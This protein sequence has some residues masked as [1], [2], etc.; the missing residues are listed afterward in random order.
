MSSNIVLIGK[1]YNLKL[2]ESHP[3]EYGKVII[4]DQKLAEADKDKFKG[5]K[6]EPGVVFVKHPYADVYVANND[7]LDVNLA[8]VMMSE[9]SSFA[10]HLGAL[11]VHSSIEIT[12]KSWLGREIKMSASDGKTEGKVSSKREQAYE[13]LAKLTAIS[14]L[15]NQPGK[16]SKEEYKEAIRIYDNSSFLRYCDISGTCKHMLDFRDPDKR[17]TEKVDTLE[18]VAP[19]NLT[20]DLKIAGS[21]KKAPILKANASFSQKKKYSKVFSIRFYANFVESEK[22]ESPLKK[23][24]NFNDL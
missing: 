6:P 2:S 5:A 18:F 11:T 19:I 12:E 3:R 1:N 15:D 24:D 20:D 4:I 17:L 22:I 10:K 13:K 9:I 7:L 23:E 8:G 16:L 21:L 14:T